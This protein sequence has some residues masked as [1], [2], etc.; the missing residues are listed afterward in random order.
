MSYLSKTESEQE[1]EII[2]FMIYKKIHKYM[3]TTTGVAKHCLGI[4]GKH[5]DVISALE[6][7]TNKKI[8][9][10]EPDSVSKTIRWYLIDKNGNK[11]L[12]TTINQWDARKYLIN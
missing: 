7:L 1:N 12:N 2:D 4:T 8:L 10:K 3:S 6:R 11:M 5:D 9:S